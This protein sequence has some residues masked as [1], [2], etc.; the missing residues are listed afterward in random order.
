MSHEDVPRVAWFL[1]LLAAHSVHRVDAA[2]G[3]WIDHDGQWLTVLVLTAV[4]PTDGWVSVSP[5]DNVRHRL[6]WPPLRAAAGRCEPTTAAAAGGK[7]ALT[8]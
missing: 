1:A 3:C 4:R 7:G 2:T 6:L 8:Q 5:E